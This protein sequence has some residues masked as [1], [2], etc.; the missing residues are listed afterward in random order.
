MD[1][2]N[3]SLY[4][5]ASAC[6]EAVNLAVAATGR[7]EL[8]VSRGVHPH[9][10]EVMATM[11]AGT[12]HR[13]VTVDLE[14]RRTRWPDG[15]APGAI[16]LQQPN[17]LGCLEDVAAAAGLARSH[18]AA[19]VVAADPVSLG[20]LRPPGDFGADVVVGER[21][22]VPGRPCRS[23]ARTWACSVSAGARPPHPGPAGR[24][25]GRR[26]R[27]AGLRRRAAGRGTGAC[28]GR[29]RR[30]TSPTR[31]SSPSPSPSTWPGSALVVSGRWRCAAPAAPATPGRRCWPSTAS[32]RSSTPRCCESTR[33][34]RHSRPT[35]SSSTWQRLV[36]PLRFVFFF[37]V[38][39]LLATTASMSTR[40]P[41]SAS[42]AGRRRRWLHR[43]SACSTPATRWWCSSPSTRTT[44][45][46]RSSPVL[47]R[48]TSLSHRPAG[49]STNLNSVRRSDPGPE[50][51]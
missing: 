36:T 40:R 11:A 30:R 33:W 27:P 14:G 4:D 42:R 2:A 46:I 21:A 45:P 22:A 35:W 20:L 12:G 29:G 50:R 8:S 44:C 38:S 28:G 26:R 24:R 41:R 10:R 18:G 39:V 16:L 9:W 37:F 1:V 25:D 15:G 34:P 17:F 19:L 51:S 6:V 13:L 49:P 7:N 43:C 32:S 5:G 23:A 48:D 31:R 3:A 47:Y